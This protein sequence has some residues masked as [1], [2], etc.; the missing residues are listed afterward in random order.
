MNENIKE[1]IKELEEVIERHSV[2]DELVTVCGDTLVL[3]YHVV[4]D[5][6]TYEITVKD[7]CY[8]VIEKFYSEVT[9][10]TIE[11]NSKFNT[12]E[13]VLDFIY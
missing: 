6:F 5:E 11:G 8:I 2:D 12:L 10:V 7:D 13:E 9:G 1:K 4:L 3:I